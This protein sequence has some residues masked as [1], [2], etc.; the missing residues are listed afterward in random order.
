MG[1]GALRG[2]SGGRAS[3]SG[4]GGYFEEG[5]QCGLGFRRGAP[6]DDEAALGNG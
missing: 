6:A 1:H 3:A 2:K 5:L 4:L